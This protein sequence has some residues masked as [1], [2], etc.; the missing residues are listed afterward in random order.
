VVDSTQA[1]AREGTEEAGRLRDAL[2][3]AQVRALRVQ[4]A[5]KPGVDQAQIGRMRGA[6]ACAQVPGL[7]DCRRVV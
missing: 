2:A 3:C 1:E 6:R 7:V 4:V 5:G